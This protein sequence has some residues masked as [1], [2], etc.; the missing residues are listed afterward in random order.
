MSAFDPKRTFEARLSGKL[1]WEGAMNQAR[2]RQLLVAAGALLALPLAKAQ[3]PEKVRR[4]GFLAARSRS[5]P[6]N[7]DVYYDAFMQGMRELGYVEG[8]NLV[9]EWR[10]ADG[11]YERLP[12]LAAELVK[13][14]VEL[15]ATN[16]T[17]AT[18]ALQRAT[19]TIPIVAIAVGDP[20]ASGFAASLARPGRNITGLSLITV[21]L[22]PK[23]L[24]LLKL[25][26]PALSRVAVL[27]NP[28]NPVDPGILKS[29]QAAAQQ[30]GVKVLPVDASTLEEIERGFATM[31]RERANAVIILPDSFFIRQRREI[32]ELATRNRLPSIFSFR[33]DVEAGGLMSYGVNMADIFRRA[34]TYVDK[35]LKGANPRELPIEQPTKIHLAINRKTAKALGLIIPRNLVIRADEVID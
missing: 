23:Y 1:V 13:M 21:D 5:T 31:R 28:G 35:I 34:A 27:E 4:I 12:T 8:K 25:M 18:E 26:M 30:V 6:S 16:S 15:I 29:V 32:T 2:R 9:V 17:P 10:F 7:P 3:Q 24:E 19:S 22:G 14:N 11:K 33:E 20:L